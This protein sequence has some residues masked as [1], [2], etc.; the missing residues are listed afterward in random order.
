MHHLL[1]CTLGQMMLQLSEQPQRALLVSDQHRRRLNHFWR[2]ACPLS[3]RH[4]L[5]RSLWFK[6]FVCKTTPHSISVLVWQQCLAM[7]FHQTVLV[8]DHFF[9]TS[10]LLP[11]L[12]RQ[13]PG[14]C[15]WI[16]STL[17]AVFSSVY[18]IPIINHHCTTALAE[19]QG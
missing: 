6:T 3:W 17:V 15:W 13:F 18:A 1:S 5:S 11:Y 4:K 8:P 9:L 2:F 14:D 16:S 7:M 10:I 12:S 19:S